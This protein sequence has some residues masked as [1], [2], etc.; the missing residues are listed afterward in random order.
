MPAQR[1]NLKYEIEIFKVVTDHLKQDT[2]QFW[3]RANFYLVALTG[4]LSA[5]VLSYSALRQQVGIFRVIPILGVFASI[6]WFGVMR[7]SI[8]WIRMWREQV[9][10]LDEEL[11]RFRCYVEVESQAKRQPFSS[12]SYLTQFLPLLFMLAWLAISVFTFLI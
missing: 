3:I 11:D 2:A 8:T 4:L 5:F 9:V 1:R 6:F 7:N 12:P 10:R